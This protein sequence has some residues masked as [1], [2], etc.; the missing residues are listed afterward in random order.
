MFS[1]L[2]S[3]IVFKLMQRLHLIN[4]L[5][6]HCFWLSRLANESSHTIS[7]SKRQSH[8]QTYCHNRISFV[9]VPMNKHIKEVN[10]TIQNHEKQM[11]LLWNYKWSI[12]TQ[13]TLSPTQKKRR[14][15]QGIAAKP[16]F[17]LELPT[18]PNLL[19]L[20]LTKD[21]KAFQMVLHKYTLRLSLLPRK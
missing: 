10:C 14:K 4:G 11:D 12:P 18:Y 1:I 20:T 8:Q 16:L 15:K 6:C 9:D 3:L 5:A 7:I 17:S 21:M 2:T 19:S 13:S